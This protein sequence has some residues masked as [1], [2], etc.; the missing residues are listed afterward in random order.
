[1]L[2]A[3]TIF[4]F[5]LLLTQEPWFGTWTLN[6]DK[7]KAEREVRYKRAITKI[8][9]WEDGLKVT[10][11]LVG[12]RGGVTHMEWVGKFDGQD[13]PVQ[14]VDYVLTNAYNRIDDHSYQIITKVDGLVSS[15][16]K[17]LISPDG[18]TLTTVTTGKNAQ[19]N[20]VSTT[21]VYDKRLPESQ[22][23]H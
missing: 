8:E 1:M 14:G 12:V 17:V 21:T 10:Y 5:S 3:R 22:S 19:G 11:D 15:T 4:F 9:P 13:Y 20:A 23:Q 2:V 16:A 18:K 7:S 6:F